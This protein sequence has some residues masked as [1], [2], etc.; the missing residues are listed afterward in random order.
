MTQNAQGTLTAH[1]AAAVLD[2]A[3]RQAAEIL[4]RDSTAVDEALEILLDAFQ[5]LDNS[6]GSKARR[7]VL[8]HARRLVNEL[9]DK[10]G[11]G[12]ARIVQP[13]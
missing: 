2:G 7:W 12:A 3:I 1:E 13:Q 8:P 6:A 9:V 4:G 5:L 11:R 10:R